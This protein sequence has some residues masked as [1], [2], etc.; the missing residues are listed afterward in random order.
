MV[1][2]QKGHILAGKSKPSPPQKSSRANPQNKTTSANFTGGNPTLIQ[3]ITN[4]STGVIVV[5]DCPQKLSKDSSL[6]GPPSFGSAL[7]PIV[8][9][10][11]SEE[12]H[13]VATQP[14]ST[15]RPPAFLCWSPS[16]FLV[17]LAK[18]GYVQTSR[19]SPTGKSPIIV[20]EHGSGS[21]ISSTIDQ[22]VQHV[23]EEFDSDY[24]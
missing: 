9:D 14:T 13:P 22:A 7:E 17:P 8:L 2:L 20:A 6:P 19:I 11:T 24:I 3:T 5:P 16:D 23:L 1:T 18:L 15:V 12:T 10:S 21:E 4:S